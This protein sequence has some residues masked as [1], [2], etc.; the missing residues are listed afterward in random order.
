MRPSRSIVPLLLLA[1]LL[2]AAPPPALPA[3]LPPPADWLLEQ[4][5]LLSAP[6]MEGRGSGTPGGARAAAHI[7]RI[8]Q[9]AG[10]TPGGDD[11]SVLQI[12]PV[13]SGGE[14]GTPRHTANVIG[15]L[16]GRDPRLR[17][18]AIV[19]GAHY[20]HLGRAGQSDSAP[21]SGDAIHPGA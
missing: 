15:L 5:R 7:S 11:G 20:D 19:I 21:R 16:P 4:V 2:G 13:R 9:E 3:P 12:F 6:E 10:L 14:T 8:F 17:R 1:I 18:E